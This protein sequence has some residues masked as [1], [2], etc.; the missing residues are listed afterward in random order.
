MVSAACTLVAAQTTSR[1]IVKLRDSPVLMTRAATTAR[2]ER[3]TAVAAAAGVALTHE[4][5]MAL[6][7]HVMALARPLDLAEA[8]AVAARLAQNPD[9]EYAQPDVR[10]HRVRT[11]NDT[12]VGAQFYLGNT[13]SGIA[14]NAAWDVTT[15]SPN[16]VVA[17]VDTGYRPHSDLAGRILPGYDFVSD[18][19]IANDGNGRDADATDPGDWVTQ[20]DLS[21]PIFQGQGCTIEDSSWHGTGVSGIIAANSDNGQ[22]LAGIDWAAKILPVRVLG[23]CGGDDSDIM[24]GIAWAAGL[25]VPGVPPNP[26]PAQVINI[27]LGGPGECTPLYHSVLS[28]ALSHGITRAIVVAAGNETADVSTSAPANCSEVI[29]VAATTKF[30]S[31][32]SYSNFGAGV[33]LS[34]PGGDAPIETDG[35]AVLF[36]T[37]TTVPDVD[38]WAKGG[39]TSFAAPMVS[40]VAS[41]VLGIAP[42][43]DAGH[44]RALLT[45]TATPFPGG[46]NCDT[47]R[48]GAGIVNAQAGVV[49]AQGGAP[50]PNY[51]GLWWNS[52]AGSESGWGINFAHQG[53]TIFASWFTYDVSGHGWWLV[54]T[55]QKTGNVYV[56]TLYQTHGPPFNAVPFDPHAVTHTPVGTGTLA[57]T[58][59]NNGTFTYTVNGT[60]QTKTITRQV[61]G[62]QPTCVWG[63]LS[64]LA[65]ARNYQDLWWNA[66]AASESGWGVNFSHQGSTI[67]L[68]WFTYDLSGSPLWLVATLTQTTNPALF[69]GTLIRTSGPRFDAFDSSKVVN[70]AVGSATLT[71]ADGNNATFAYTVMIAPLP[72]P[73]SQTKTITR[74]IFAAPGTACR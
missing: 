19:A 29:A 44:L 9:V 36:N 32:A 60:T 13:A 31:L 59:A 68:T 43:L 5:E 46:S 65:A 30:G 16:V 49:M 62:A 33:A 55:A 34:A 27:S 15:G 56:G 22:W 10:R 73:V 38:T 66:P 35:I 70:E 47:S 3:F 51:Q 64:N 74:E 23:K 69:T 18:P 20:A 2:I 7:A 4:R 21:N 28:S 72:G 52:P 71:F 12:H 37:G 63:A 25:N 42:T 50:A 67:F 54:M 24:D 40:G 45:A 11:T 6:G 17:V 57:F 53:D 61:F 39:G 26:Y 48:C 58:D 1:L 41:L 8:R 14:A